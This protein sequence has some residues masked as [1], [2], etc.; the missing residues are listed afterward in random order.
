M[1]RRRMGRFGVGGLHGLL[2]LANWANEY[3]QTLGYTQ[4]I[5]SEFVSYLLYPIYRTQSIKGL[6]FFRLLVFVV[7]NP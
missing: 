6:S 7:V 1:F 2:C 3:S 4:I 5:A